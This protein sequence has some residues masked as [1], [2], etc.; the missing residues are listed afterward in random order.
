MRRAQF[1]EDLPLAYQFSQPFIESSPEE[2]L[3]ISNRLARVKTSLRIIQNANQDQVQVIDDNH[4]H[5][6][7]WKIDPNMKAEHYF[8]FPWRRRPQP[9]PFV[10]ICHPRPNARSYANLLMSDARKRQRRSRMK[11]LPTPSW[12]LVWIKDKLRRA[13]QNITTQ[14]VKKLDSRQQVLQRWSQR[15]SRKSRMEDAN[16]IQEI[17]MDII[18]DLVSKILKEVL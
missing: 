15:I 10:C 17:A 14:S 12:D 6:D 9:Q 3:R 4:Q 7:G 13:S 11:C 16:N 1:I 18:E 8:S 5:E 2:I